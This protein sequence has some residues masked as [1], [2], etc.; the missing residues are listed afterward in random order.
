[1]L[2][3][4]EEYY[5]ALNDCYGTDSRKKNIFTG[6]LIAEDI[7]ARTAGVMYAAGVYYLTGNFFLSL[8]ALYPKLGKILLISGVGSEVSYA[9]YILRDHYREATPEEKKNLETFLK[10]NSDNVKVLSN[11]AVNIVENKI[12][13]INAIL[14][15][16]D[17]PF[18]IEKRQKLV[19]TLAIL[20]KS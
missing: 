13:E 14:S 1:M 4:S 12:A 19:A 17:E 8:T 11:Q 2:L 10:Q 7:A 5:E 16:R 6:S 20:K 3:S 18:L 9:T 15:T